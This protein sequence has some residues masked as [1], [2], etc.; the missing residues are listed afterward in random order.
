MNIEEN[1]T[2]P[3]IT[4]L[5]DR[6]LAQEYLKVEENTEI[7]SQVVRYNRKTKKNPLK[8]QAPIDLR[9]LMNLVVQV[10][11]LLYTCY[12]RKANLMLSNEIFACSPQRGEMMP[13]QEGY[14]MYLLE[15]DYN[16]M[17]PQEQEGVK[18]EFRSVEITRS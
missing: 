15:M 16:Q 12:L 2:E 14:C 7:L 4:Q 10:C 13:F 5:K 6:E 1:S 11:Y 9:S 8:F 3:T 18:R 17:A